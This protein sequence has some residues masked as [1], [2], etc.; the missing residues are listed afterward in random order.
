MK[1][2]E[3]SDNP[4]ARKNPMRVG[5]GIGSGKG[6][7]AGR[8]VKGQKSRSGVAIKGFE[9]G[10]MPLY[11][12]VA[13]RGFKNPFTK[14]FAVVNLG[15][16]QSAIDSKRLDAGKTID[17]AAL[18]AAGL[19]S[20][21]PGD[22]VR[23][24]AKGELT[25]KITI[26][27]AGAS[28]SAIELVEKAGGKVVLVEMKPAKVEKPAGQTGKA[29]KPAEPKVKESKAE[30]PKAEKPK[31]EKPEAEK[32]KA[33]VEES[34]ADAPEASEE[35]T[36]E[37]AVVEDTSEAQAPESTEEPAAE[38]ASDAETPEAS[39]DEIDTAAS[40]DEAPSDDKK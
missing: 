7:T 36:G 12:R 3:L 15:R 13:K 9:G 16:M 14:H 22:G 29:K 19:I 8:G 17:T 25:A 21:R 34:D 30:K 40:S 11:R 24:L 39:G 6:K 1:L 20:R 37:E 38:D 5:R 35:E 33:K 27:V 31:T 10:Q 18:I 32:P 23:L 28:K 26:E 2:N 4:G